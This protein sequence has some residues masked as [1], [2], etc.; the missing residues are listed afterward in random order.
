LTLVVDATAAVTAVAR[1]DGFEA[2]GGDELVA[3][4]GGFSGWG[5]GAEA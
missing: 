5:S 2:F 1:A 4:R 3:A